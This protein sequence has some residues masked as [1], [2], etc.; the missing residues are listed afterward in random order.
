[1]AITFQDI[2]DYATINKDNYEQ[3]KRQIQHGT[4][5]PFVGAGL[6]A[7]IYPGWWSALKMLADDIMDLAA[8]KEI[9]EILS[10]DYMM[11]HADALEYAA[12]RLEVIWTKNVFDQKIYRIFSPEKLEKAEVKEI[13]C[14]EAVAVLPGVFPQGVILTTNYDHVLEKVYGIYGE[15]VHSCD[16]LHQERLNRRLKEMS[17]G[18]LLIKLHGDVEEA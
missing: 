4:V 15:G 7:C 13:L 3:L 18:A 10:D 6:S 2:M 8:K 14:K 16:V 5:I 11:K 12:K 17:S 1:M 9:L